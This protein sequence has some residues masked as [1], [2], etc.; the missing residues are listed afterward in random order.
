MRAFFEFEPY[1]LRM[2]EDK[3]LKFRELSRG[4]HLKIEA[5]SKQES[6]LEETP[7]ISS[8]G[9]ISSILCSRQESELLDK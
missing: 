2:T 1:H 6:I 9:Q 3:F 8:I 4:I 5:S 7:S